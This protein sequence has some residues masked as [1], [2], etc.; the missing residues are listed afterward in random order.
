MVTYD[1]VRQIAI[2]FP[3]VEE[4]LAFG[5]PTLRVNKRFLAC[6]AKIDDDTLV[7][8]M[9]DAREREFLL[10][11]KPEVYYLTDHYI[12]FECVLVR[13]PQAECDELRLLIEQ[14][15]LTLAP[16]K[17]IAAYQSGM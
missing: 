7:L 8:K 12:S 16:K 17:L 11:S 5:R 15:W 1:D 13:M 6:M 14:S 3:G 2:A 10:L 4:H 9:R